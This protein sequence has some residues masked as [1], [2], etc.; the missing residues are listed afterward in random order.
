MRKAH[1]LRALAVALLL[2]V[3]LPAPTA[4]AQEVA[5]ALCF[6]KDPRPPSTP[7]PIGQP[8]PDPTNPP[9]APAP[10]A[11]FCPGGVAPVPNYLQGDSVYIR[12]QNLAEGQTPWVR[13]VCVENCHE[14][15]DTP[16]SPHRYWAAWPGESD[17][18]LVF[19]RDFYQSGPPGEEG[20]DARTDKVPRYNSTW[21]AT[22]FIAGR[23][24]TRTFNVWLFTLYRSTNLTVMPGEEHEFHSSG[25]EANATVDFRIE[26]LNQDGQYVAVPLDE[27]PARR[28]DVRGMIFYV[29]RVPREEALRINECPPGR[30]VDCYRVVVVP[31]GTTKE[32]ETMYF[33]VSP[34]DVRASFRVGQYAPRDSPPP[35]SENLERTQ[36]VLIAMELHYPGGRLANGPVFTPNDLPADP[37][38]GER[39]MRVRVEKTNFTTSTPTQVAE[40]PMRYV[41]QRFRWE[42][43]WTVQRDLQLDPDATFKLRL[44][45]AHD[46]WGNRVPTMALGNYTVTVARLTAERVTNLTTLQRTEEGT[47]AFAI[48]YHNGSLFTGNDNVSPLRGCFFRDR[49]NGVPPACPSPS[50]PA[51]EGKYEDGTWV[52]RVKYPRTYEDL[53][54]HAFVLLG[55]RDAE[56]KWGNQVNSTQSRPF[57]VIAASPTIDFQTVMRG[58]AVTELERGERI[59]I[60][61]YVKY[62]DGRPFNHTVRYDPE[63]PWSRILNVTVTRRGA[64]DAVQGVS[65]VELREVDLESGLWVGSM[66][67]SLDASRTPIGRWSFALRANDTMSP[68]PNVNDTVFDRVVSAAPI[69]FQPTR[70]SPAAPYAGSSMVFEFALRYPGQF[71][72]TGADVPADAIRNQLTAQVYRWDAKNRTHYGEPLSG[73][74]QPE[75]R[76]DRRVWTINY[77]VPGHL[78]NASFVFLVTGRDASGNELPDDAWSSPFTPQSRSLDRQVLTPPPERVQ[79][80]ASATIVFAAQDGDVGIDGTGQPT[81]RVERWNADESRWDLVPG[82]IDVRQGVSDVRDHLGVFGVT[83]TTAVGTYRFVLLGREAAP[84]FAIINGVSA[85]FTVEPTDVTRAIHRPPTDLVTKGELVWFTIER[86]EGDQVVQVQILLNGRLMDRLPRPLLNVEGERINASWR[87]PFEAQNGNYTIHIE[88]RDLYGNVLTVDT[89]NIEVVAAQ[90]TGKLLGSPPR[91]VKRGTELSLLF[92]IT[93]P[94]GSFYNAPETPTVLVF[95]DTGLVQ[96]ATVRRSGATFEALWTPP[97]TAGVGDYWIEISGQG[98]GGNAFPNL[99][100]SAFRLAPGAFE[101]VATNNIP[102]GTER[103]TTNT[104]GIPYEPED[105][106]VSFQLAYY[107]QTSDTTA[108]QNMEPVTLTPLPHSVDAVAGRY[109][110]RFVSDQQTPVGAYRIFLTGEDRLGNQ[111]R[112]VS[113]VFLVKPT[114][115]ILSWEEAPPASAFVENAN[116]QLTVAARY[117]SGAIMDESMGRPSVVLL[118]NGKP[119]TQR[120]EITYLQGRW[121]ITWT[122][123]SILSDGEYSF[124]VGG[125]DAAGNT[126]ATSRSVPYNVETTTLN[127]FSKVIPGPEPVLLLLG[128]LAVALALGRRAR[129]E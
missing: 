38:G 55:G 97:A 114:T 81:I 118:L 69:R 25:L 52:F 28:P 117:K 24:V 4:G 92:G 106:F 49:G 51:T 23:E 17:A 10:R 87:V 29:W 42:A 7:N 109:V 47:I 74:I 64:D 41:A 96:T 94:S 36:S 126:I 60:Q 71:G 83:T 102:V 93:Y 104:W 33:R 125:Q 45:E 103:M 14:V 46:Q 89:P 70:V 91:V 65:I 121:L 53:G 34:A 21:Q 119:T 113:N 3:T 20:R 19:P 35:P 63:S 82:G 115:V 88:G 105:R 79:R 15:A 5:P 116:L 123:P 18:T 73:P 67:L 56:D 111:I 30:T 1:A 77:I 120:P 90:L 85:N 32:P 39:T 11:D 58:R 100:T 127:S 62:R 16:E 22:A 59:G 86:Q 128:A 78:Y 110:A 124:Q 27:P 84:S 95:N 98:V 43:V 26:R 2:T 13:V 75:Y 54:T 72:T 44:A 57:E 68:D 122:A 80:G 76:S 108:V 48:K 50:N 61:A 101:R 9:D 107:G 129:R 37:D 112:A 12:L 40:V 31:S 66:D 8:A 99:R 6:D